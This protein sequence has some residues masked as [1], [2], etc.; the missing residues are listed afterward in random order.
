M[1]FRNRKF[2]KNT[3]LQQPSRHEARTAEAAPSRVGKGQQGE[4]RPG[5]KAPTGGPQLELSRKPLKTWSKSDP[6]AALVQGPT[7]L[8]VFQ[9]FSL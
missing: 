5:N 6:S 9:I 1:T 4:A 2:E 7:S 8:Y 3:I